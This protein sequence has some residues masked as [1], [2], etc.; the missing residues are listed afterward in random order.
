MKHSKP[1]QLIG[2]NKIPP[3]TDT[4]FAMS[5]EVIRLFKG[6]T[7]RRLYKSFSVKGLNVTVTVAPI[8]THLPASYTNSRD[9]SI[10]GGAF[11]VF[12][13]RAKGTQSKTP[14]L[15]T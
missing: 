13:S 5:L 9:I 3:N 15:L 12:P 14:T 11:N 2:V 6:L 8:A 10:F 4:L 1:Q 7:A